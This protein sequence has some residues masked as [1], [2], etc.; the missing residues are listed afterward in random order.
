M[1][2]LVV[3]TIIVSERPRPGVFYDVVWARVQGIGDLVDW[4]KTFE[5]RQLVADLARE[6]AGWSGVRR[7]G[8]PDVQ[9]VDG[10]MAILDTQVATFTVV[11]DPEDG[12]VEQLARK[13]FDQSLAA[14]EAG[15]RLDV[16]LQVDDVTLVV[17]DTAGR[18]LD[19]AVDIVQEIREDSRFG[20]ARVSLASFPSAFEDPEAFF[21][22]TART[23]EVDD[24]EHAGAELCDHV[25]AVRPAAQRCFVGGPGKG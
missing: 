16:T 3:A 25:E 5:N 23:V 7:V 15:V 6:A 9:G 14:A 22:V 1:L 24:V 18:D 20:Q 12:S 21:S 17:S 11:V 10:D 2:L 8:W 13:A 4:G 19:E